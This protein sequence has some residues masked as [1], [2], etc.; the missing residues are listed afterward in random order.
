MRKCVKQFGYRH[1]QDPKDQPAWIGHKHIH[2]LVHTVLWLWQT[3]EHAFKKLF[4][5]LFLSDSHSMTQTCHTPETCLYVCVHYHRHAHA[6]MHMRAGLL[7]K[8]SYS[9]LANAEEYDGE[10]GD[11]GGRKK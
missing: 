5:S 7:L 2:T 6:H 10:V 4:S 3:I 8:L 1:R 9:L 11:R